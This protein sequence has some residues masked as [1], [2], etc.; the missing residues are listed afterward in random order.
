[1]PVGFLAENACG[2]VDRECLWVLAEI[3]CGGVM[4]VGVSKEN[5]CWG[6]NRKCLWGC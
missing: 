2:D 4:P 5:A 6:M 3:A 1:M